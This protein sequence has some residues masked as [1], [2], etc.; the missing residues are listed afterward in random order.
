MASIAVAATAPVTHRAARASRAARDD[1]LTFGKRKICQL[2]KRL[3]A[4]SGGPLRRIMGLL[5][6][7]VNPNRLDGEALLDVAGESADKAAMQAPRKI[8]CGTIATS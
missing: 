3:A 4:E 5:R 2:P 8:I 6:R 1:G 7:G